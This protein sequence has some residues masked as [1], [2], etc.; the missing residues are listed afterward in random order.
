MWMMRNV[1]S[2]LTKL[3]GR[4]T[5][6][7]EGT[8][9]FNISLSYI[10]P[11]FGKSEIGWNLRR[12]VFSLTLSFFSSCTA[13]SIHSVIFSWISE[14]VSELTHSLSEKMFYVHAIAVAIAISSHSPP[15]L[16]AHMHFGTEKKSY[17]QHHSC[18]NL[19][20]LHFM[21]VL[22]CR[23]VPLYSTSLVVA[24]FPSSFFLLIIIHMNCFLF[25]F[26]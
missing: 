12:M 5:S 9:S 7:I 25:F 3:M 26:S 14:L 13:H 23:F 16:Y 15:R 24:H 8:L 2:I 10:T 22:P 6:L 19:E 4:L 11:A 18:V 20:L 1:S 21:L 17:S